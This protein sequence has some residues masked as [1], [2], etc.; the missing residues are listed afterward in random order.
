[1]FLKKTLGQHFLRDPRILR[2]IAEA[3]E[4]AP[5]DTVLE[6]GPGEGALTA[7]LLEQAGKV[8]AVEKDTRLI[9]LLQQK[10][11]ADIASGK[12]ELI[13]ADILNYELGIRNYEK[14]YKVV[15]NIPY[16]ITGAFLKKFLQETKHPPISM[17][18][19]LQKEVARRIVAQD[20]LESILSI[21]V[22]AYGEPH[23]IETVKA[24]SFVPP[25]K[26]DSAII[27]IKNISKSFFS[28]TLEVQP[29]EISFR[30]NLNR[31]KRF[32]E[33]LKKG[34]AH[35]RKL[36][37]SN[38]GVPPAALRAASIP[39]KSRAENLSLADWKTLYSFFPV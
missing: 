17:T 2:K 16:Y 26:V 5:S 32:F 35:P 24:G 11:A 31:E 3:A 19:L 15:A 9:P 12:L 1:M 30:L 8:V 39:E 27:A 23:Y 4:L 18:L 37:S 10:F 36:L 22:K 38:L 28:N 34:F 14:G 29:L 25:P 7:L 6:V 21:S 33:L 20:G 13:H